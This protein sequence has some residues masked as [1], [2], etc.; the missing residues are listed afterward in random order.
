M[1]LEDPPGVLVVSGDKRRVGSRGVEKAGLTGE[2]VKEASEIAKK[3]AD[4]E[5]IAAGK[6][7]SEKI[8]VADRFYR[9]VRTKPL[10]LVHLLQGK[11]IDQQNWELPKST[12]GVLVAIGLSFPRLE[13]EP[14]AR[15]VKYKINLVKAREVFSSSLD[16]GDDDEPGED[17]P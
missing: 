13:N 12:N 4:E 17:I 9:E 7:P 3:A 14:A 2:Q 6:T 11:P 15:E 10:L 16:P 8:N 5:A 1:R